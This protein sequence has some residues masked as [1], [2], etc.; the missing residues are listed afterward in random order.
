MTAPR[1][2]I[3]DFLTDPISSKRTSATE[4]RSQPAVASSESENQGRMKNLLWKRKPAQSLPYVFDFA[5]ARN[6]DQPVTISPCL[7]AG[8]FR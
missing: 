3:P 5:E 7:I 1:R 4:Y 6:P 2:Y 8:P